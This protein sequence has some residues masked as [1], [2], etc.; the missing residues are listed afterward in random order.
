MKLSVDRT[1][2]KTGFRWPWKSVK[3]GG[4]MSFSS[5]ARETRSG[6]PGELVD[7]SEELTISLTKV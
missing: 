5:R 4:S 3:R 6:R 7:D 1:L 2:E